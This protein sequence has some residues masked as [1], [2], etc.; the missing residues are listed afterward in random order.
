MLTWQISRYDESNRGTV[1]HN[2]ELVCCARCGNDVCSKYVL[3]FACN[4]TVG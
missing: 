2:F 4:R 3:L 1:R